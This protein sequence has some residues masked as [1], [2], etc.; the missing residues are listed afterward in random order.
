MNQTLREL[1]VNDDLI[2]ALTDRSEWV[3]DAS[4]VGECLH[5]TEYVRCQRVFNI[6]ARN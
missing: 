6:P 3:D 4:P 2:A 1:G 5:H